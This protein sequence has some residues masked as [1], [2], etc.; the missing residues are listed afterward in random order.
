MSTGD[1]E[2]SPTN[3][4][5]S[6]NC[7]AHILAF[8]FGSTK[9][10]SGTEENYAM[11]FGRSSTFPT[12]VERAAIGWAADVEGPAIG[13]IVADE[14]PTIGWIVADE[15]PA[16]GWMVADEGPT[17]GCSVGVD[18]PT[19]GWAVVEAITCPKLCIAAISQ[20]ISAICCCISSQSGTSPT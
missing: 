4:S 6:T 12:P 19:I 5:S 20:R 2:N 17:I 1:S 16:I 18:G 3:E 8:T 9:L 13:W 15:G 14:G 10:P 11:L 7:P